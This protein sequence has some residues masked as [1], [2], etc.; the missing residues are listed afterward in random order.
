M[1]YIVGFLAII[2]FGTILFIG[3][4]I[5]HGIFTLNNQNR[6]T[7][8]EKPF[9][10]TIFVESGLNIG[11]VEKLIFKNLTKD[12]AFQG[13][14]NDYACFQLSRFETRENGKWV[15]G[16]ELGIMADIRKHNSVGF[17]ADCL[18]TT[19]QN[20]NSI[21][22][23]LS[24]LRLHGHQQYGGNRYLIYNKDNQRLFYHSYEN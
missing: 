3:S 18:E 1:R 16:P 17:G 22:L 4:I 15:P 20:E 11:D 14:Y 13:D 24:Y 6:V 8:Q 2:G 19:S 5:A 7:Q 23:Y 10:H 21:L 12:Q 9:Y